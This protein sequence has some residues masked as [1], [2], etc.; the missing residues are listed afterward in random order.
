MKKSTTSYFS[1]TI[2]LFFLLGIIIDQ[3]K[4]S[5][6][7]EVQDAEIEH[8]LV[9]IKN[10]TGNTLPCY[11]EQ[12]LRGADWSSLNSSDRQFHAHFSGQD[13]DYEI[14]VEINT[15]FVSEEAEQSHTFEEIPH[16]Y[17][18]GKGG[19]PTHLIPKAIVTK[20]EQTKSA[21]IVGQVKFYN[22][23]R[24]KILR[25][26][27]VRELEIFKNQM[28]TYEGDSKALSNQNQ[29]LSRKRKVPFPSDATLM[30]KAAKKFQSKIKWT[31][32][33]N[34]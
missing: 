9:T 22:T 7:E 15:V 12:N 5:F 16:I 11:L 34:T 33:W 25:T 32:K 27:P 19:T 17:K 3:D 23:R 4:N 10:N 24:N 2:L 13:F 8:V 29:K 6:L 30:C 26:E 31:I 1:S 28:L 20:T 14:I 21:S 18:Y